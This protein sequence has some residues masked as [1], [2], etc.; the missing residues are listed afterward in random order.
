MSISYAIETASVLS[1]FAALV[2]FLVRDLRLHKRPDLP[3]LIEK[4]LTASSI[5]TAL[6]LLYCAIDAKVLMQLQGISIYVAVAGLATL[7][8]AL[9][10]LLD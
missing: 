9:E 3:Y 10:G 8:V 7:Y 4:L 5:P 1:G 2:W 6:A